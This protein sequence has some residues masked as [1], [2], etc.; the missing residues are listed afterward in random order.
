MNGVFGLDSANDLFAKLEWEFSNLQSD[1]ANPYVAYNFFVTAWHL[2][3]W[4]YPGRGN[5]NK[6]EKIRNTNIILGICEHIAVGAKHFE[7]DAKKH[8]SVS[9]TKQTD[10]WGGAWGN[11]WG[12]SWAKFLVVKLSGEAANRYGPQLGVADLA[13]HVMDYWRAEYPA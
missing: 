8:K 7:P 10:A 1:K 12:D 9:G 3:E 4:Q 5:G 2:L 11:S 13:N 6:R